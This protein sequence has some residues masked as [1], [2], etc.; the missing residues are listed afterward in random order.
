MTRD[1][2]VA[3]VLQPHFDAVRD[4]FAKFSPT[5][6]VK[7]SG[8][9]KVKFIIDG[10]AGRGG[11]DLPDCEGRHF[12]ATRDDGLLMYYAPEIVDIPHDTLVAI[13]AHEFGHAADH[14][15]PA[16]W[17]MPPRGPG[18]ATWIGSAET[19][20]HRQWQQLWRDRSRDQIEWA[21]DGIAQ[22]VIGLRI[23]YA[24]ACMLQSFAGGA[25]RPAGLR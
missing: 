5:K 14:M 8:L 3:A 22:A 25:E 19:K 21:A 7:L 18:E 1:E 9:R 6:G 11:T 20:Q 16:H 24:G 12:A 15:Y 13:L 10:S 2:I 4:T 17:V 23:G